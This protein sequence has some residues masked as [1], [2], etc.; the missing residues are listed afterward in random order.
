MPSRSPAERER[1]LEQLLYAREAYSLFTVAQAAL[2]SHFADAEERTY[3]WGVSYFLP[4]HNHT[5]VQKPPYAGVYLDKGKTRPSAIWISF[6][7]GAVDLLD[8]EVIADL[9]STLVAKKADKSTR[10]VQFKV[11]SL[12]SWYEHAELFSKAAT[13]VMDRYHS[14][15]QR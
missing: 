12:I 7:T 5:Q 15:T 2:Q 4:A 9:R 11:P 10:G 1:D 6:F 13:T 8:G 14:A 3:K